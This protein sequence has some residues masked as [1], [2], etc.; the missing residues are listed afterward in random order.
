MNRNGGQAGRPIYIRGKAGWDG[1]RHAVWDSLENARII[2]K[3]PGEVKQQ[4]LCGQ[5][6]RWP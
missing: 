5:G 2:P 6:N 1:C 3:K 4:N